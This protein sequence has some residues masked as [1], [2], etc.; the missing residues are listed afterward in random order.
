[1]P[2]TSVSACAVLLLTASVA[3]AQ[4]LI[5]DRDLY[6]SSAGAR[7]IAAADFDRDGWMDFA[8]A[9]EGPSGVAVLLNRTWSGGGFKH[10]FLPLPG[11][12]FDIATG[13]F[14]RDSFPDLA[15]ANADANQIDILMGGSTGFATLQI[16]GVAGNPRGLTVADMDADGKL[17]IIYTKYQSGTVQILRGEG[18]GGFAN[19]PGAPLSGSGPQGVA[20]GDFNR[21]GRMDL[22]VANTGASGL[23][24]LSQ[25]A[26]GTFVRREVPG[27]QRMN[28]VAVGDFNRDGRLDAAAAASGGN[29][30]AVYLGGSGGLAHAASYSTGASPRG[31]TA[32]DIDQ[33]GSLDLVTGNRGSN[34]ISV[35]LGAGNGKFEPA[36][37]IAAG[38]GSRTVAVAD[39][40]NDGR[41]DVATGNESSANATVL[42]NSTVF[43]RAA[44][45]FDRRIVGTPTTTSQFGATIGLAD[46]NEDGK[47]DAATSAAT[48]ADGEG[49]AVILSSGATTRVSVPGNATDLA[50]GDLNRDGHADIVIASGFPGTL[51]TYFGNGSGQFP[52]NVATP[53]PVYIN[54]FTAADVNGDAKTDLVAWGWSVDGTGNRVQIFLGT[55]DGRFTAGQTLQRDA[56]TDIADVNRDGALDLLVPVRAVS[57]AM[58]EPWLGDGRGNF[59]LGAPIVFSRW[60][61]IADAAIA[62]LNHDGYADVVATGSR[63]D[64]LESAIVLGGA[65]G[66][67]DPDYV[68]ALDPRFELADI[69]LDGH[70]DVVGGGGDGGGGGGGVDAGIWLGR[71]DGS[72]AAPERFVYGAN[73]LFVA[74]FTQDGLPDI[75]FPWS[76]NAIAVLVNERN[77]INTPPTANAGPDYSVK[78][79]MQFLED[80]PGVGLFA[81]GSDQDLHAVRFEWRN[82]S[83]ALLSTDAMLELPILGSGT[84]EFFVTVFDDR[85]GETRDSV[86]LTIVPLKDIVLHLKEGTA[87]GFWTLVNDAAAA[88]GGRAYDLNRGAP[89]AAAPQANATSYAII[90]FIA[91]PSQTYK[92]WVRLKA[93]GNNWANDSVFLQFSGAADASGNPIAAV[94]TAIG[95]D[96]NLEEC[97]GCGISGWGWRDDAWGQR[98]VAPSATRVRFSG[99]YGYIMLQ[100]RE[101]GVSIDQIVMSSERYVTA[102]PGAVKNDATILPATVWPYQFH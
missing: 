84:Y 65:S 76:T 102:R 68:P 58:L 29:F 5:F 89:K 97:S 52:S 99:S 22:V 49:I 12:P 35:L 10:I 46:F 54:K 53:A 86:V 45:S 60:P 8:T 93:D 73:E 55:G 33:D 81:E 11:G 82:A 34:D 90:K 88:S 32:V 98:G 85:G 2:Q 59:T 16:V 31:I 38:P 39:F 57:G 14:N 61:S 23:V 74:D 50:A 56:F 47:L 17:D 71:G 79:E 91:D 6:P 42:S 7:G 43:T 26:G 66:F 48:T 25:A 67:L 95:L 62:D 63:N 83:G 30:V 36:M 78:Y 27:P 51:T 19:W 87:A 100:T 101:D 9:N 4:P 20:A 70:V 3:T 96:V 28:V 21:D 80:Y 40:S 44:F 37:S 75:L 72:F 94:G 69:N 24:V 13:D 77:A 1:M 64:E 41:L 92:V 18:T 15:I